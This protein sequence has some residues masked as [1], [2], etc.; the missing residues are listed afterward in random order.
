LHTLNEKKGAT[1]LKKQ[2]FTL[3]I[4]L[5]L[6]CVITTAFAVD[7][8]T[9]DIKGVSITNMGG[10]T[11]GSFLKMWLWIN[12]NNTIRAKVE[13]NDGSMFDEGYLFLQKNNYEVS[14]TNR[15]DIT[16][17]KNEYEAKLQSGICLDD[18]DVPW[19]HD[20]VK[21]YVRYEYGNENAWVGPVE[22]ER[23]RLPDEGYLT[24]ILKPENVIADGGKWRTKGSEIWLDNAHR[25]SLPPG[26]YTIE[27]K[28]LIP[29]W[30]RPSD[31]DVTVNRGRTTIIED[32]YLSGQECAVSVRIFPEEAVQSGA[33]WR[34][35]IKKIEDWS[36]WK[37]SGDIVYGIGSNTT[38]IQFNSLDGWDLPDSI[39]NFTI[40]CEQIDTA[41]VKYCKQDLDPAIITK[42]S[43]GEFTDKVSLFWLNVN[44]CD[45]E[46]EVWRSITDNPY[47][48][49]RIA[50]TNSTSYDDHTLSHDRVYYYWVVSKNIYGSVSKSNFGAPVVG[51]KK[52]R[53]PQQIQAS[54]GDYYNKTRIGSDPSDGALHYEFWRAPE[55]ANFDKAVRI[56][57]DLTTPTYD[58]KGGFHE[59]TYYYWVIAKNTFVI[60]APGNPDSGWKELEPPA[61]VEAS[62]C[63]VEGYSDR[64]DLR[65][66]LS[67]GALGYRIK[68]VTGDRKRTDGE[69]VIDSINGHHIDYS[70]VPGVIYYYQVVAYNAF[71]ESEPSAYDP[72]KRCLEVPKNVYVP[73][74]QSID[75][76]TIYWDVLPVPAKYN[77]LRGLDDNPAN[78]TRIAQGITGNHYDDY[79]VKEEYYYWIVADNGQTLSNYGEPVKG[80]PGQCSYAFIPEMTP[81]SLNASS[82][83]VQIT[84][85]GADDAGALCDWELSSTA[86]WIS[87]IS[88]ING[89]GSASITFDVLSVDAPS[90]GL[91]NLLGNAADVNYTITRTPNMTLELNVQGNGSL[92]VN[93]SLVS[94][95][96]NGT[97]DIDEEVCIEAISNDADTWVFD[98]WEGTDASINNFCFNINKPSIITAHFKP[99]PVILTINGNDRVKITQQSDSSTIIHDLPFSGAFPKNSQ[100]KIEPL[101]T[102]DHGFVWSCDAQG[103]DSTLSLL[104]NSD[105]TICYSCKPLW[106]MGLTMTR[107]D[108]TTESI[109]LGIASQQTTQAADVN[110]SLMFKDFDWL[111][112]SYSQDFRM[113]SSDEITWVIAVDTKGQPV[114]LSW[115]FSASSPETY[116]QLRQGGSSMGP[117]L[118]SE[119]HNQLSCTIPASDEM[120]LFTLHHSDKKWPTIISATRGQSSPNVII[121]IG[122]EASFKSAAPLP[123]ERDCEMQI[124]TPT[125]DYRGEQIFEAQED[126]E[127]YHWILEINP[128]GN[129]ADESEVNTCMI[130]WDPASFPEGYYAYLVK[131]TDISGDCIIADMRQ[132]RELAVTGEST[133]YYYSIVW[134]VYPPPCNSCPIITTGEDIIIQNIV[135]T[136]SIA[137][138]VQVTPT[139]SLTIETDNT[140]LFAELPSISDDGTLTFTPASGAEGIATITIF[141]N[142]N[143]CEQQGKTFT[144]TI[145]PVCPIDEPA[146]YIHTET[147]SLNKNQEMETPIYSRNTHNAG[148]FGIKLNF[149]ETIFEAIEII[150][151]PHLKSTGRSTFIVKKDVNNVD[152]TIEFAV[153]SMGTDPGP[154][155]NGILFT[156]RW[157]TLSK[158]GKGCINFQ[159]AQITDSVGNL[160]DVCMEGKCFDVGTT[161]VSLHLDKEKAGSNEHFLMG[162][163]VDEASGIGGYEVTVHYESAH[164]TPIRLT[165]TAYFN[166]TGRTVIPL[167]NDPF[168]IPG[169]INYAVA[170]VGEGEG[171]SYSGTLFTVDFQVSDTL[172]ESVIS[173]FT[174]D[175]RLTTTD[176]TI[177]PNKSASV[178]LQIDPCRCYIYDLNCDCMINIVDVMKVAGRYSLLKGD[179][180]FEDKFDFDPNGKIDIV[181]VMRV[182]GQYGWNCDNDPDYFPC[183]KDRKRISRAPKFHR[184]ATNVPCG[185]TGQSNTRQITIK[186]VDNLGAFE[187]KITVDPA[188]V[189]IEDVIVDQ[190]IQSTGRTAITPYTLI[191]NETGVIIYSVATF[192]SIPSTPGPS[193]DGALVTIKWKHMGEGDCAFL[194]EQHQITD[195]WGNVIPTTFDDAFTITGVVDDIIVENFSADFIDNH[196]QV[197]FHTSATDTQNTGFHILRSETGHDDDY[198]RITDDVILAESGMNKAYVFDD[199]TVQ[200]GRTYY[201]R[202]EKI[203]VQ[204]NGVL[205]IYGSEQEAETV[206]VKNALDMNGDNLLNLKDVIR[207]LQVLSGFME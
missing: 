69:I 116:F 81:L 14:L 167:T 157:K 109:Q 121:G 98:H 37:S 105:K 80:K 142:V 39:E 154:D 47:D 126:I 40:S 85:Q 23:K 86:D 58:D 189:F 198:Y 132:T 26:Q 107:I 18:F 73:K 29:Y 159:E 131:G 56:A 19:A 101:S 118:V 119:M 169:Q 71:G 176:G 4:V 175:A 100:L 186:S 194:M 195:I 17:V 120:Q 172:S 25:L 34:A 199:T 88:P 66:S 92:K 164:A 145:E 68:V 146:L 130:S 150:E 5:T 204:T 196:V 148:G 9:Y 41:L 28:D 184:P 161:L 91:I 135:G 190:Y 207:L 141:S 93:E 144:I 11:S 89:I 192:S 136:Q 158:A 50:T 138:F 181:D 55:T 20:I 183:E 147:T 70:A 140:D 115:I 87:N 137:N 33:Q 171:A 103:N 163:Q 94:H 12:D 180:M 82:E 113:D 168:K 48:A 206:V 43:R 128:S 42:I 201:Y 203:N 53:S 193:G 90:T 76:V 15:L 178:S 79:P 129:T 99:V 59:K 187:F 6:C 124:F 197:T 13:K 134:S 10:G 200:V 160:I 153:A 97:F 165:P 8:Y 156:V 177:I 22:I 149:D 102:C 75:K 32:T 139:A 95:P 108:N 125:G 57:S 16:A 30:T 35:R 111:Y 174:P 205:E 110:A 72:G 51:F 104:M 114:D 77:I 179:P 117:V 46:F 7:D 123:F 74:K 27:Y 122:Q 60:S 173:S 67:D 45:V 78:A 152:G 62:D 52:L 96:W 170:T 143:G 151:G 83:T 54:D 112:H 21:I 182:A 36:A 38:T 64:I 191:D 44:A 65:Y 1:M 3:T 166:E 63:E 84:V 155:G 133:K 49:E 24:V 162:L 61:Q 202:L 2:L 106:E 185:S 127:F 31:I 188:I